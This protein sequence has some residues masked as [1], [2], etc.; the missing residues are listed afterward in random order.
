[1]AATDVDQLRRSTEVL[2]DDTGVTSPAPTAGTIDGHSVV[3]AA[4]SVSDGGPGPIDP[5]SNLALRQRILA[6]A[7]VRFLDQQEPLVVR[8]PEGLK[9]PRPSFFT[10]LDVPWLRVTTVTDATAGLDTQIDP[11]SLEPP[12]P[13]ASQLGP[14]VYASATQALDEGGT[15]QSVIPGN[16]TLRRKLFTEVAGNASYSAAEDRFGALARMESTSTWVSDNLQG[17]TVAAPG[18]VTLAS[19]S[20]RFSAVVSNTLDVPV[21]VKVRAVSDPAIHVTDSGPL[22]LAPHGQTN[23]L[24]KAT[25]QVPG[26]HTVTLELTNQAGEALGTPGSTDPFPMRAVQVSRLI[27]VIIGA[28]V[29]LLFAAIVVRLTRRLLHRGQGAG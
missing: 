22:Q 23:V 18:S 12:D 10:G 14:R 11:D 1:M 9:Q 17:I 27:W 21:T 20:G 19:T 6:D 8:I 29:A 16:K 26:V 25:T 3:F 4:S 24:L 13:D 2:L 7:A 28:G 15:L 5:T